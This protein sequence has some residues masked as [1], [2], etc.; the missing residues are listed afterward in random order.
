MEFQPHL[1]VAA[2]IERDGHFL[3]VE[4]IVGGKRVINQPAGHVDDRESLIDAVRREALEETGWEFEP[5]ALVGLY[6][7]RHPA[8]GE[9][10]IRASFSGTLG[11]QRNPTP[12]DSAILGTHWL[13]P[14][15]LANGDW[16]LRS[17]LVTRCFD[18][19]LAGKRHCLSLIIDL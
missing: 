4:E 7:W 16:S 12:P 14:G 6:R 5:D 3:V 11:V 2:I 1:T 19:F 8:N 13:T 17:P 15:Q 9:T 18:D 10:F